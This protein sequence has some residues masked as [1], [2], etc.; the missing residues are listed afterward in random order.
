MEDFYLANYQIH[1]RVL[2]LTFIQKPEKMHNQVKH[3]YNCENEKMVTKES[4]ASI[5]LNQMK[6]I[7]SSFNRCF[8]EPHEVYRSMICPCHSCF[9]L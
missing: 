2:L 1:I 4:R 9:E 5:K 8:E 7:P 6:A 3:D